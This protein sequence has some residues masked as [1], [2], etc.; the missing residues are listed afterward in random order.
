MLTFF[1][2]Q[3]GTSYKI[4][5]YLSIIVLFLILQ[6]LA[7]KTKIF[8]VYAT[9]FVNNTLTYNASGVQ[10]S[11][12]FIGNKVVVRANV[13]DSIPASH[14]VKNATL[15]IS[16]PNNQFNVYQQNMSTNMAITN[17]YT[18]EWNYTLNS[19]DITGVYKV[20]VTGID[21]AGTT[22]KNSTTFSVTAGSLIVN[23]T[24]PSTVSTTNVYR[25]SIFTVNATITCRNGNCGNVFGTVRYN[26]SSLYPDTP[27]N[28][29]VNATPLFISVLSDTPT[30]IGNT[31]AL[32]SRSS[33]ALDSSGKTHI[34]YY[35]ETSDTMG[36]CNNTLGYWACNNSV[37]ISS[38]GIYNSIAVD[39]NDKIHIA[40]L[41][42]SSYDLRYCNN[43]LGSW[44][45]TDV[46]TTGSIG[47]FPSIAIDTNN[48]IHIAHQTLSDD[49]LQY[50]NNTL[51]T[52]TCANVETAGSLGNSPSISIDTNNKIH[53]VHANTTGDNTVRYCNSTL[54]TWTC[55]NVETGGDLA[56]SSMAMDSNNKIHIAYQNNTLGVAD[57]RYCNNT[58]G[59]WTC[60]N[61][62]TAGECAYYTAIAIDAN[63]RPH[64]SHINITDSD[65]LRYCY[66]NDFSSW[67]CR[68]IDY[69]GRFSDTGRAMAIKKGRLVDSTSS[70]PYVHITYDNGN[71]LKHATFTN[72]ILSCGS[73]LKDESCD[74][75][76]YVN[77]TGSL[78][79][80]YKIGT[81]FNSS[82][83]SVTQ[84]HTGNATIRIVGG[85]LTVNLTNPIAGSTTNVY[86]NN[87]FNVNASITC[88]IADCGTVYGTL[89][90]NGSSV[91]PDTLMNTSRWNIPFYTV[92]DSETRPYRNES[93]PSFYPPINPQ[94]A[95][96]NAFN[97]TSTF[98]TFHPIVPSSSSN[99]TAFLYIWNVSRSTSGTLY[100]TWNVT[101]DEGNPIADAQ[102]I[103]FVYNWNTNNYV[104]KK[105]VTAT[106]DEHG[107]FSLNFDQNYVNSNGSVKVVFYAICYGDIGGYSEIDMLLRD[108][109]ILGKQNSDKSCNYLYKDRT[110]LL[111]W[112]I[113]A[114]GTPVVGYKIGVLFNSSATSVTQNH[115]GNAT[116]IIIE[117]TKPIITIQ[118]PTNDTYSST[119]VWANVTLNEAGSWCGRSLDGAA[120]VT[121]INSTGNWNNQMTSLGQNGH[122]VRFCCNNTLNSMNC[123]AIQYFTVDTIA[124]TYSS[125]V[126]SPVTSSTYSSTQTYQFNLTWTD[127]TS[128][129]N[130]V[131]IEHNLTGSTTPH[132]T[133]VS[134]KNGNEYYFYVN[135]LAA[136]KYVY[137]WFANDTKNNMNGTFQR[138]IYVVNNATPTG[139]LSSSAGWSYS[140]PTQTSISYSESNNGDSGCTYK[141]YR[142]TTDIS[143]GETIILGVGAYNY[144]LN[145]TGCA[146]YSSTASLDTELLTVSQGTPDVKTFINENARNVTVTYPTSATIK[147]NS[148]SGG[149]LPSFN[150]YLFNVTMLSPSLSLSNT[151]QSSPVYISTTAGNGTYR[152]VLNNTANANWTTATNNTIFL[153]VNKNNTNP[154]DIYFVNSSGTYKNQNITITSGEETT[155][156][157]TAIYQNSG[158]PALYEDGGSTTNP[159]TATLAVGT[160]NYL[161]NITGNANYTSNSTGATYY[162]IVNAA[163]DSEKPR[164]F[165]NSTNSTYAGVAVEHRLRWRS[166]FFR[167]AANSSRVC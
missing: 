135:S 159:R 93:F 10:L 94:Y 22:A 32:S 64:I 20:N 74:M 98:A 161:G 78:D 149:V 55:T 81:L 122:N 75:I 140:Y 23:L 21:S 58:L 35:N 137:K 147:G 49:D 45:C 46:N 14:P 141:I 36:Y 31:S 33:I 52:W 117:S 119:S 91:Y 34:S 60:A 105:T 164:Y 84:N 76:W 62:E 123:S 155:A 88:N 17:G 66:S 114:T 68:V 106:N 92:G 103:I 87:T 150:L 153:L 97:D 144:T 108:T 121:M 107:T 129:V 16:N 130:T 96:D 160:H 138:L 57:L 146:N 132:N 151:S 24:A 40:E 85:T 28:S 90:Y 63:D 116:I 39:S 7:L 126:T 89:R 82:A 73:L 99:T 139:S 56:I 79:S 110:C 111:N 2:G 134:T 42:G 50:C 9:P 3:K 145:T 166:R 72:N 167:F 5:L 38:S 112:T 154:V 67:N 61:V 86:Q 11:T 69:S 13:T 100:Y 102:A 165:D 104:A 65:T 47:W 157:V 44:T 148:S 127:A 70:S 118:S 125:N 26:A 115:T 95:F 77:A 133:T 158:T 8:I 162:I 48:K 30:T 43:T 83:T 19:T 109:Y 152:V 1:N 80:E 131:L 59:T 120:N 136:G 29:T 15:N 25:Y 53:I 143:T 18:F 128:S 27:I 113:N 163:P 6:P 71:L 124:P 51:G 54:G 41:R 142:N 101:F 4:L 37:D 156:N 12:F